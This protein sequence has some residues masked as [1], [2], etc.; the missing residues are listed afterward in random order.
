MM[1][2]VIGI[3]LYYYLR[4]FSYLDSTYF[5]PKIPSSYPLTSFQLLEI[6]M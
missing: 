1:N 3:F 2:K 5:M 4:D 6:N